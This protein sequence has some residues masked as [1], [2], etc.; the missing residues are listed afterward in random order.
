ML[1]EGGSLKWTDGHLE[2]NVGWVYGLLTLNTEVELVRLVMRDFQTV[3]ANSRPIGLLG[4]NHEVHNLLAYDV[5]ATGFGVL[6]SSSYDDGGGTLFLNNSVIEVPTDSIGVYHSGASATV[7]NTILFNVD[8]GNAV[9]VSDIP[10][11]ASVRYTDFSSMTCDWYRNAEG[12]V[13]YDEGDG[14][15]AADPRF[16]DASGDFH[17]DEFSPCVDAGDPSS[18]YEDPDGSRNDLGIYGGPHGAW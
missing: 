5:D 17:L 10:I 11:N 4:G 16:E 2:E 14:N 3:N 18:V 8:G 13:D 15:L 7:T 9:G 1:V 6:L 12:C